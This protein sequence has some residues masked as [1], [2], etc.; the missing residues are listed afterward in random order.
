MT[1]ADGSVRIRDA[2]PGDA[3]SVARIWHTGWRDG[4]LDHVAP[5]LVELRTAESFAQRAAD[6]VAGTRVAEVD[7]A[8]AGFVMVVDDEFEQVYVSA[9]HRGAG[10]SDALMADAER[11]VSANGHQIAWLAVVAGNARARRFYERQGWCDAGLF[12]YA[13]SDGAGGKISVPSH[14]YEKHLS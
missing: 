2:Q 1:T 7:G 3:D 6:R 13:A 10:V 9:E 5:Q 12:D 14:R 8:L 11:Q 4:H